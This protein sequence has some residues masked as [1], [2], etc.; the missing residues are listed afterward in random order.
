MRSALPRLVEASRVTSARRRFQNQNMLQGAADQIASLEDDLEFR[1][2]QFDI[3]MDRPR[4][5]A[6]NPVR[7]GV[8]WQK[9]GTIIAAASLVAVLTLALFG[10]G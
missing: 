7:E 5:S 10:V 1:L 2:R 8:N 4:T 9:W 3:D 6:A